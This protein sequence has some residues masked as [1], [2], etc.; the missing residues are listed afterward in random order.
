[1]VSLIANTFTSNKLIKA[2]RVTRV[3][4]GIPKNKKPKFIYLVNSISKLYKVIFFVIQTPIYA[5]E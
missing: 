4:K 1:M 2:S 5:K 3:P